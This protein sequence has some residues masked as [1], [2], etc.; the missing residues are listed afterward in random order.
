MTSRTD[1]KP[2]RDNVTIFAS[3]IE[4]RQGRDA[5]RPCSR[6]RGPEGTPPYRQSLV[7]SINRR[8]AAR[9]VGSSV[10]RMSAQHRRIKTIVFVP[11]QIADPDDVLPG[12]AR[13]QLPDCRRQ[14]LGGLRDDL[15]RALGGADQYTRGCLAETI[16]RREER[17]SRCVV[18]RPAPD[19]RGC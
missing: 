19:C 6:E 7:C 10:F 17:R 14:F 16:R 18:G 5:A 11:K 1:S 9:N 8:T 3:A 15:E 2:S 4:A 12:D 13:L